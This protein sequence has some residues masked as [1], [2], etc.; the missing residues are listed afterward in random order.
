MCVCIYIYIE[1]ERER[2]RETT[3]CVHTQASW[4]V[5]RAVHMRLWALTYD[6]RLDSMLETG[7]SRAADLDNTTAAAALRG[8]LRVLGTFTGCCCLFAF[9]CCCH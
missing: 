3:A 2:E 4:I 7:H 6:A 9:C 1:R 5:V 8:K